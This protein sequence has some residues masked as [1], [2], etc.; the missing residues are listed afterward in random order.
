MG[1]V[2]ENG[3]GF[4]LFVRRSAEVAVRCRGGGERWAVVDGV[5]LSGDGIEV[6]GYGKEGR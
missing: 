6:S 1:V 2:V 5:G 4:S 3:D